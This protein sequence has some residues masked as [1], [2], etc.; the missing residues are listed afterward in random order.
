MLTL[1]AWLHDLS[2]FVWRFSSDFGIRWYGLAYVGGFVIAWLVLA[3]LAKKGRVLIPPERIGD[4]ILAVILGTILG[5]RLGYAL[6]YRPELFTEF[7]ST[8]PWWGLLAINKGG[9]A[10][11]GGMIGILIACYILARRWKLPLLHLTDCLA[12]VAP[13]GIFL[14]RLANFVN[15]ELLG[16]I[17]APPGEPGPWWAV[18]F[19][20]ELLERRTADQNHA[21]A[22]LFPDSAI[23]SDDGG[24]VTVAVRDSVAADLIDRVQHHEPAARAVIEPI[25]YSRHPSQLYQALAEG[26]ILGAILWLIWKKPRA[27]GVVTAWFFIVYGIGR[28]TT[29]IWRLPDAQFGDAGRLFG[30]SRGQWLSAAMVAAGVA[31]LFWII[32]RRKPPIGQTAGA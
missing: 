21:L 14:G 10:S 17:V 27:A 19:P 25:L 5:G 28:I 8:A 20:Q 7:T 11:H 1:A 30:L 12:L 3:R 22:Q 18:K 6:V 15:G 2:P 13:F 4:F 16:A 29:E 26:V 9:M 31:L 23:V 24:V 32:K